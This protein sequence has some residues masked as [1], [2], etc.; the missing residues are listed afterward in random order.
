MAEH[1]AA[2]VDDLARAAQARTAMALQ[3][4][5]PAEARDEAQI[6]ALALVRGQAGLTGERAHGVLREAAE[7]EREPVEIRRVERASM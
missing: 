5:A 1:L 3:E 7:R 6:L 4:R 2:A